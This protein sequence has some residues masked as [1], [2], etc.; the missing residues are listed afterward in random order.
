[1]DAPDAGVGSADTLF[2]IAGTGPRYELRVLVRP[3]PPKGVRF[4]TATTLACR[5]VWSSI[6]DDPLHATAEGGRLTL[7]TIKLELTYQDLTLQNGKVVGCRKFEQKKA[8]RAPLVL[9]R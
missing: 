4:D 9:T 6:G 7:D 5:E 1:V 3:S 8:A 2:S